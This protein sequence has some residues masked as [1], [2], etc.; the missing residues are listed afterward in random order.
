VIFDRRTNSQQG[1]GD[2]PNSAHGLDFNVTSSDANVNFIAT[3]INPLYLSLVGPPPKKDVY[4][5]LE[6]TFQDCGYPDQGK[7]FVF[8]QDTDLA[9]VPVPSTVLLLG[10]GLISLL[11]S[12]RLR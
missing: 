1:I 3:Y 4:E 7:K 9:C 5:I 6:I 8:E 11:A 2:T 10:S 12:R